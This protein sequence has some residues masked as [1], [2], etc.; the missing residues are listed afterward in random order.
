M[1]VALE[2]TLILASSIERCS[3][4]SEEEDKPKAAIQTKW[5]RMAKLGTISILLRLEE[6]TSKTLCNSNRALN[7]QA[8]PQIK[9][10]KDRSPNH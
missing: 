2:E 4:Q 3:S 8:F 7:T 5:V 6:L 1:L 9:L 10:T